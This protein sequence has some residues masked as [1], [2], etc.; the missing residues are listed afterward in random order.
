LS[1]DP[2][3]QS[4]TEKFRMFNDAEL[5][6]LFQSGDLTN[7]ARGVALAESRRRGIDPN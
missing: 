3:A 6:D 1:M 2:T 5:L 7:L 4:L